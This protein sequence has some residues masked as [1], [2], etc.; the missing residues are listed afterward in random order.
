VLNH[1]YTFRYQQI[2]TLGLLDLNL[3]AKSRSL[4]DVNP[5]DGRVSQQYSIR[6][7]IGSLLSLGSVTPQIDGRTGGDNHLFPQDPAQVLDQFGFAFSIGDFVHGAC[8]NRAATL[9]STQRRTSRHTLEERLCCLGPTPDKPGTTSR[10][11]V[12][13]RL[14]GQSIATAPDGVCWE[15]AELR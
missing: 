6:S 7:V 14:D 15:S 1:S 4:A 2:T 5:Q 12:F 9:C 8:I 10:L 3:T 13:G 11:T